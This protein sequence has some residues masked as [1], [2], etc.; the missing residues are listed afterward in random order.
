MK[1]YNSPDQSPTH[2]RFAID[3][4]FSRTICPNSRSVLTSDWPVCCNAILSLV[5]I[6]HYCTALIKFSVFCSH[7][8]T[9]HDLLWIYHLDHKPS[10]KWYYPRYLFV[11]QMPDNIEPG[12]AGLWSFLQNPSGFFFSCVLQ[13]NLFLTELE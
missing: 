13:I 11:K 7:K 12:V 4:C 3:S 10:I 8:V 5:K 2:L 9:R 1:C 6:T